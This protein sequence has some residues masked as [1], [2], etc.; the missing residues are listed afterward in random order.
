VNGAVEALP[1]ISSPR[2]PRITPLFTSLRL[3]KSSFLKATN[4]KPEIL[5]HCLTPWN[6]GSASSV[7]SFLSFEFKKLGELLG[8]LTTGMESSGG[9]E[10]DS[11]RL[12][13]MTVRRGVEMT[14]C[15]VGA[16]DNR[17]NT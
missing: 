14:R 5:E 2:N 17:N 10:M 1:S 16:K 11:K 8:F 12:G 3:Q 7:N 4:F 13:E 15:D 9:D 6:H